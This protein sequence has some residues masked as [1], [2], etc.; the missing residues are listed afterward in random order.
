MNQNDKTFANL[1]KKTKIFLL[2][3][4][5]SVLISAV[6]LFEKSDIAKNPQH[7][8]IDLRNHPI[9]SQ[10]TFNQDDTI[11][12]I[13]IQ[14]LYLP[15][16]IIFEAIKRDTILK[17]ALLQL[18]REIRYYSFLKGADVNFFLQEKLLDGGVGGDMPALSASSKVDLVIP[19]RIQKGNASIVSAKP[20]LTNDIKGKR[21]AYP[22]GS[23]SHYFLLKLLQ[24]AGVG[25]NEVT[26]IPMDVSLMPAALHDQK[27]DVFSAWEPLVASAMKQHPEFFIPYRQIT[28]GYL[29]FLND[30]ANRDRE[31]VSHILA[32]AIRAIK[33]LKSDRDALVSACQWNI[34][35]M[36][37]L[38]GETSILTARE[39]A[40]LAL[41]DILRYSSLYSS[42]VI[43]K[44][45]TRINDILHSEYTFLR[46]LGQVQDSR[47]WEQVR[48]GFDDSLI[49]EILNNPE[50]YH[51]NDFSYDISKK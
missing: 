35:E 28:T 43:K 2:L 4:I 16:G 31:T 48:K 1:S 13:G 36:E 46:A 26:L 23:V 51:L 15:T 38:T 39:I 9:Y 40:Q 44:E 24:S 42:I 10:Y 22:L 17:T 30:V 27:V 37:R 49:V 29:Y 14:P 11:I 41:Q 50:K 7:S 45:N 47:T 6:I 19:V 3:F 20:M 33:W 32:A 25:E 21:I 12:N 18:D 5:I 34:T 8:P